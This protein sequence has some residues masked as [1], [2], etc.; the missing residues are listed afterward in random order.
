MPRKLPQAY[1]LLHAASRSERDRNRL[2][3]FIGSYYPS[4]RSSQKDLNFVRPPSWKVLPFILNGMNSPTVAGVGA[5]FSGSQ[6][7]FDRLLFLVLH[8]LANHGACMI[9]KDSPEMFACVGENLRSPNLSNIRYD[10]FMKFWSIRELGTEFYTPV[11]LPRVGILNMLHLHASHFITYLSICDMI[12]T[13]YGSG[14]KA[15]EF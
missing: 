6:F 10:A 4:S 3:Q 5:C 9:E 13:N 14:T 15:P 8:L 12:L 1:K 7:C 11:K 2:I